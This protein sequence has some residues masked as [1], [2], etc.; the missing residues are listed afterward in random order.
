[1]LTVRVAVTSPAAVVVARAGPGH[2]AL[3]RPLRGPASG[4]RGAAILRGAARSADAGMTLIELLVAMVISTILIIMVSQV[5][6]MSFRTARFASTKIFATAQ[7]RTAMERMMKLLR[8]AVVPSG[9]TGAFVSASYDSV[10]FYT[11]LKTDST[12]NDPLP[13][14]VEYYWDPTTTCL[15]EAMTPARVI[16]PTPSLGSPY[17]WD[18]GRT[19][20]C[21][22]KLATDPT[23]AAPLLTYYSSAAIGSD[24]STPT[25]LTIG[26]TGMTT[27]TMLL[28]RSVEITLSVVDPHNTDVPAVVSDDKVTLDNLVLSAGGR[29]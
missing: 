5:T 24:G 23:A 15:T 16:T 19:T 14:Y 13:T 8:V 4:R 12:A 21:L 22:V 17:A 28:I 29:A 9:L 25:A 3:R 7:S 11:A 1:M 10:R 6:M 26:A 18:T 2:A 20:R 27:A